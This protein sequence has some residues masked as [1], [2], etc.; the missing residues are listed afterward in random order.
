LC[1]NQPPSPERGSG[2]HKVIYISA[3]GEWKSMDMII[4]MVLDGGVFWLRAVQ[5]V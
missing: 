5:L 3:K 4:V 1:N 2:E